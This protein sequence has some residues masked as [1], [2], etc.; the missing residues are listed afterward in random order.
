MFIYV[1]CKQDRR[2]IFSFF[3]GAGKNEL[4]DEL[5]SAKNDKKPANTFLEKF[6][7]QLET[8][9]KKYLRPVYAV[10]SPCGLTS[11]DSSPGAFEFSAFG[12]Y[13]KASA[14]GGFC[15]PLILHLFADWTAFSVRRLMLN[16][17]P[18][19]RLHA[20]E[21][22]RFK[23]MASGTNTRTS[24]AKLQTAGS[25]LPAAPNFKRILKSGRGLFN[26]TACY[27]LRPFER[28]LVSADTPG[29]HKD[30]SAH[31]G[32]GPFVARS[33]GYSVNDSSCYIIGAVGDPGRLLE[34]PSEQG[35]RMK[36]RVDF[37]KVNIRRA[38]ILSF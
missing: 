18:G 3:S 30:F 16:T 28:F 26:K 31:G 27:L 7:T 4:G 5:L 11:H 12:A 29:V 37:Q 20:N 10:D 1:P 33:L 19:S 17:M 15:P 14:A 23:T 38:Y 22:S 24:P 35:S 9:T 21:D 32:G 25:N 8:F 2:I 34:N 36:T 6:L 13:N